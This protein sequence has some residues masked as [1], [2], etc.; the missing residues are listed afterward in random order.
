M[1]GKDE[2]FGL[3]KD[4]LEEA[5]TMQS[6]EKSLTLLQASNSIK[7][8]IIF[9]RAYLSIPKHSSIPKVCTQNTNSIKTIS[10]TS[11]VI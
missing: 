11:K 4:S 6:F 9:N 2:V 7:C 10:K 8:N 5:I 3:V 1:C